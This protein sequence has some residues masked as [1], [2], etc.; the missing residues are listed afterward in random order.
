ML[1]V[2]A[3]RRGYLDLTQAH[4]DDPR[5]W[6]ATAWVLDDLEREWQIDILRS[7]YLVYSALLLKDTDSGSRYWDELQRARR[8]MIQ[9]QFPWLESTTSLDPI[10]AMVQQYKE[11]EKKQRGQ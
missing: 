9:L 11:W 1:L 2:A 3:H 8:E 7:D 5:W 4:L 10:K 6:Q